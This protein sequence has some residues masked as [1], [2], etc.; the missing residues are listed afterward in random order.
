MEQ[1]AE[2]LSD[3]MLE[4]LYELLIQCDDDEDYR[5]YCI[6]TLKDELK[7]RDLYEGEEE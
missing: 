4:T 6:T 5:I 7:K 2:K 1:F 3:S